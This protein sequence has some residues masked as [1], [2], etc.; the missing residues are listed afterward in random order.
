MHKEGFAPVQTKTVQ[1]APADPVWSLAQL[2][3]L[4]PTITPDEL[5]RFTIAA[6]VELGRRAVAFVEA[7]SELDD[8]PRKLITEALAFVERVE[9]LM[10]LIGGP[11]PVDTALRQTYAAESSLSEMLADLD[12][13]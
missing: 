2:E 13:S 7:V 10:P 5:V 9:D 1:T 3:Q 12:E 4:L 8:P 11:Q 6:Q